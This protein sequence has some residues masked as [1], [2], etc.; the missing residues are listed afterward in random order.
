MLTI[1]VVSRVFHWFRRKNGSNGSNGHNGNGDALEA[2]APIA[3]AEPAPE[4]PEQIPAHLA[5]AETAA[6]GFAVKAIS[7]SLAAVSEDAA[8][9]CRHLQEINDSILSQTREVGHLGQA[10]RTMPEMLRTHLGLAERGN[11]LLQRQAQSAELLVDR[12][13]SLRASLKSVEQSAEMHLKCLSSLETHHE[14]VLARYQAL[15]LKQHRRLTWFFVLGLMVSACALGAVAVL[16]WMRL[17]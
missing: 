11:L 17:A 5:Q 3:I 7:E 14:A 16:L 1:P 8:G 13:G 9:S 2:P 10:L 6:L 4:P 12:F 15:L